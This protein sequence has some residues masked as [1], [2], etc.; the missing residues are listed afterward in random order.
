MYCILFLCQEKR[1]LRQTTAKS[2]KHYHLTIKVLTEDKWI[3]SGNRIKR[4]PRGN[5][6]QWVCWAGI[7]QTHAGPRVQS[8]SFMFTAWSSA[9]DERNAPVALSVDKGR[10]SLQ[11]HP[12][13]PFSLP[14]SHQM[15]PHRKEM[16]GKLF[17]EEPS[18]DFSKQ[19]SGKKR[20]LSFLF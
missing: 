1:A 4:K 13:F 8:V 7:K 6:C 5:T 15:S 9:P 16:W 14:T 10:L 2:L 12:C 3:R 20:V 17:S 18:A 19:S 11:T